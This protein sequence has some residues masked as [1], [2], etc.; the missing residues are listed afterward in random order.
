[1]NNL[2]KRKTTHQNPSYLKNQT[3]CKQEAHGPHCSSETQIQS[4]NTFAQSYNIYYI[5]TL[6]ERKKYI[7]L[8]RME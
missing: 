2:I 6:I 3:T 4:I 1:M 5:I 8:L 7:F